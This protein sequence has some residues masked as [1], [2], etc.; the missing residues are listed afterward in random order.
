[1]IPAALEA[2]ALRKLISSSL[3]SEGFHRAR[4][5]NAIAT[6]MANLKNKCAII[7]A[8]APSAMALAT[9]QCNGAGNGWWFIAESA[10]AIIKAKAPC[11]II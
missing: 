11:V 1:M 6:A 7:K 9:A 3:A 4:A 10:Y 5:P 8:K 2:K